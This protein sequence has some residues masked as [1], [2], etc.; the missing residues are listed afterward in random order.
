MK[1]YLARAA[2]LAL[3]PLLIAEGTIREFLRFLRMCYRA[4]RNTTFIREFKKNCKVV[5]QAWD[6]QKGYD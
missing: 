4:W 3:A 5:K 1:K 2:I 6:A